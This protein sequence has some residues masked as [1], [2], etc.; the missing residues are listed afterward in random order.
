MKKIL[1]KNREYSVKGAVENATEKKSGENRKEGLRFRKELPQL[2]T[3]VLLVLLS[4]SLLLCL[5]GCGKKEK[6]ADPWE[7]ASYTQDT[8]LGSGEKTFTLEAE[9]GDR[10]VRFTIHTDKD[11]AGDA[12]LEN[13][14]IDGEMAQYGMYIKQVNG[15][16]ADYDTDGSYWS[17]YING[18]YALTGVD[19]TELTEN[20]V[21]RLVYTK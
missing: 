18:E 11:T 17:F 16:T 10:S 1:K 8:E 3:A 19:S 12:L 14:L 20:A 9:A 5:S 7:N 6:A 15:I 2:F 21:Y 13:G 4:F